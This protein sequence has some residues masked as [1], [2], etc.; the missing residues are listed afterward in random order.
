[1]DFNFVLEI[2]NLEMPSQLSH[3]EHAF[4]QALGFPFFFFIS[5]V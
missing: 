2:Q 1:M 3:S 5:S 4:V